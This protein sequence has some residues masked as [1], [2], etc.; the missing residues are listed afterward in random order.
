MPSEYQIKKE[1]A[2]EKAQ[3][4]RDWEATPAGSRAVRREQ[5]RTENSKRQIRRVTGAPGRVLRYVGKKAFN[6]VNKVIPSRT[7][8]I[9]NEKTR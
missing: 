5:I 7:I 8:T 2:E 1:F 4:Q 3:M 9:T 6:A